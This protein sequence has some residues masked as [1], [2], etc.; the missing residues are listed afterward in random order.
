MAPAW[1]ERQEDLRV[2]FERFRAD[3]RRAIINS[4]HGIQI[5][6]RP[7]LKAECDRLNQA[8]R[9][10]NLEVP[11]VALHLSGV[12]FQREASAASDWAD[13]KKDQR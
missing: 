1:I 13:K 9:N 5:Q 4:R 2:E 8:I 6:D 10:T 12:D 3:L 11:V 7:D